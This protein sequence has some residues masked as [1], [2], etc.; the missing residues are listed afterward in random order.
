MLYQIYHPSKIFV[1]TYLNNW[2]QFT[3][4][5]SVPYSKWL[6]I[7]YRSS[8][9][10]WT[11]EQLYGHH[12]CVITWLYV[13]WDGNP[14]VCLKD[15]TVNA[16]LDPSPA[17]SCWSLTSLWWMLF[18]LRGHHAAWPTLSEDMS[19]YISSI[20]TLFIWACKSPDFMYVVYYISP[21]FLLAYTCVYRCVSLGFHLIPEEWRLFECITVLILWC[22]YV[23]A[24]IIV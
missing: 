16:Q 3:H 19:V 12:R 17:L 4:F 18:E 15:V 9:V 6:W 24:Y 8:V 7:S 5:F 10:H 11:A 23:I 22:T 21:F 1:K 14:S 13:L 20:S 2:I